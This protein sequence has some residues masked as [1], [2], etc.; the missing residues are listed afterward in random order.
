VSAIPTSTSTSPAGTPHAGTPHTDGPLADGPLADAPAGH[1]DGAW[2]YDFVASLAGRPR[3]ITGDGLRE[4]LAT[5]RAA[6]PAGLDARTVEVPSGTPVLDW[7]VPKEWNARAARLTGPDGTVVADY[8]DNPLHLLGYSVPRQARMSLAELRPHLLSMP[9][10]PDWIPYRTSYYNE[11][12]GFCLPDRTLAALPDGEYDVAID[13][14]LAD[15][16]LTY[17]EVA[18]PGTERAGTTGAGAAGDPGE[19]LVTTHTCHPAMANDNGSGLAVATL[20]ARHLAAHPLRRTVRFLFIPGTIGSITWLAL[21]ADT[22]G[23]LAGGLVLTGLGDTSIPTYKRSR[24]GDAPVDRAMAAA[25]AEAGVEHRIVEFSPYGYD[26]RQFCSPGYN[27]G[28]GRFGR[29]QH[30]EYPEYHT[31]ADNLEFVRPESLAESY[32]LALRAIEIVDTDRTWRGTSP[33]GEPQLGRRGLYRA[34]GATMNR[35]A[36]EMGL[37]WVLNLADGSH[38]LLDMA[39][40]SGLPFASLAQAADALAGVGLLVEDGRLAEDGQPAEQR[41]GAAP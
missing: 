16:S 40:R 35:Q 23:R 15:G 18:V 41:P 30:G 11:N 31:S 2:L 33:Y 1:A 32:R 12:W 25:L 21:N 8:A 24:R 22:V 3:S 19:L 26:E 17:L 29:G 13:T 6:L 38:S 10:R 34:I 36:I 14:S 5:V 39:E 37:L 9:D 27:L 28:I 7:T 20:L 4:T